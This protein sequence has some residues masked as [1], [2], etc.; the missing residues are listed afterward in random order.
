MTRRQLLKTAAGCAAASVGL[1]GKSAEVTQ[2]SLKDA[3][4]LVRRKGVSPVELTQ[5]LLN[6]TQAEIDQAAVRYEYQARMS[7]L[8]FQTG[9]LK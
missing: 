6:K 3:S 2:L 5:A 7:A 9:G 8:R 1:K 4:G